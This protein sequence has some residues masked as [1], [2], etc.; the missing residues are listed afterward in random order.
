MYGWAELEQKLASCRGPL[1]LDVVRHGQ[2]EANADRRFSGASDVRLTERG[3]QQAREMGARLTGY[4]DL[5]FHSSL[6][7]SRQTLE[8]ALASSEAAAD[9]VIEDGRLAERSLGGL[10]GQKSKPIAEYEQDDFAYAPEGGEPYTS[11]T[12]RV[13]S[14]LADLADVAA[15]RSEPLRVLACT[16]VGPMRIL[17]PVLKQDGEPPHVLTAR[18][19]NAEIYSFE[20]ARLGIPRFL[21]EALLDARTEGYGPH[22]P[23]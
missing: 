18:Y 7:R 1:E 5:A 23:A 16:H 10:E 15:G 2:T 12:Q 6:G 14:F 4:Y 17:V 9:S 8:L 20:V 22:S 3:E 21:T 19:P 11:V 13:L